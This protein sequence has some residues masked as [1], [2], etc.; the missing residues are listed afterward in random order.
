MDCAI[1]AG[2]IRESFQLSC[3]HTYCKPCIATWFHG[4]S[5]STK[6][7]PICKA[8]IR[9][10][11]PMMHI[12][13]NIAPLPR[14]V[15]ALSFGRRA[16]STDSISSY[17]T[18]SLTPSPLSA[19]GNE[20][21]LSMRFVHGRGN[22][23]VRESGNRYI[24]RFCIPV[25][26]IVGY[27]TGYMVLNVMLR[28]QIRGISGHILFFMLGG[29]LYVLCGSCYDIWRNGDMCLVHVEPGSDA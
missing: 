7:C 28:L 26:I 13:I 2:E 3:G 10:K 29:I 4:G 24:S 5:G 27:W 16:P 23:E 19:S 9:E 12:N 11:L 25:K 17:T 14:R 20:T 1:C 6:K 21:R 22:I 8:R 15:Q 18:G